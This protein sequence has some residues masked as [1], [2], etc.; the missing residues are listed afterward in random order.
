MEQG[1]LKGLRPS[2]VTLAIFTAACT[3][4]ET[5]PPTLTGPSEYAVSLSISVERDLL[6]RNG[7]DSSAVYVTAQDDQGQPLRGLEVLLEIVVNGQVA[8]TFG[9]LLPRTI[10]TG[11]DGRATATYTAP[12]APSV[13]SGTIDRVTIRASTIGKNY[14]LSKSRVVDIRLVPPPA[15]ITPGAPQPLIHASKTTAKIN[16]D[17]EF[18][19]RDSLV[20]QPATRID[21]YSWDWGDSS[22]VDSINALPDEDHNYATAGTFWVTLTVRDEYGREGSAPL[23]ITITP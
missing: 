19:G 7:R 9:T 18:H 17:I 16:E 11:S 8:D 10:P 12:T 1:M 2:L 23:Q 20:M 4:S 21:N 14:Q 22:P 3:I 15:T 6:V 13:G 5:P